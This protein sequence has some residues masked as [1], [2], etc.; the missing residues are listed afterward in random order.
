MNPQILSSPVFPSFTKENRPVFCIWRTT[1]LQRPLPLSEFAYFM[2]SA[3]KRP[4]L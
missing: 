3:R 2:C 4:F 1:S